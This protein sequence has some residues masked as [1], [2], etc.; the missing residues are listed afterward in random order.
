MKRFLVALFLI[1]IYVCSVT[2]QTMDVSGA[3]SRLDSAVT[4]AEDEFT[5]EDSYYLGRTVA[6]NIINRYPV[7]SAKPELTNYLNLICKALAINSEEPHWFNGY[8][9]VILNDPAPNAFSTPAG[10]IFLSRGLID[11][12]A[13]EDMLAAIIA[14]EMAHIQLEHGTKDI[15]QNRVISNLQQDKE[16]ISRELSAQVQQQL[17]TETVSEMVKTLFSRGY[18]QTQEFEA[19]TFAIGLLASAGYSP[20]GLLE[21]LKALQKIQPN[22]AVVLSATHPT[23]AQR[24]T[25][26]NN[27]LSNFRIPDTSNIR[28]QRFKRITGR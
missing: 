12:A 28:I 25:N 10:H 23:A 7:Y 18:S 26:V 14:H 2:A 6:V 21:I 20:N 17:F 3:L 24:I 8:Y 5:M 19:D 1:S 4:M 9:V 22:Q 27:L 11:L 15:L 16:R 13:S